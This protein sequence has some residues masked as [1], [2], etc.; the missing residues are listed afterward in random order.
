MTLGWPEKA[1]DLKPRLPLRSILHMESY[2]RSDEDSCLREYDTTMIASGLYNGRQGAAPGK[3]VEIEMENYG[4]MERSARRVS[5]A[6][7]IDLRM[8][9][10]EQGFKL[11]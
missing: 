9:L 1:E 4:W 5:Q 6:S 3:L 7:R 11:K 10:E 8:S 2:D